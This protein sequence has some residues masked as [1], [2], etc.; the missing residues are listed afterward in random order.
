MKRLKT[1]VLKT[2]VLKTLVGVVL[3][4]GTVAPL[5]AHTFAPSLFEL[6]Q[7]DG[8]VAVR[9]K[10]P[11]VRVVD[12]DLGGPYPSPP[13]GWFAEE[14]FGRGIAGVAGADRGDAGSVRIVAVF[15]D[16]RGWKGRAGLSDDSRSAVRK[17][18]EG[19]GQVVSV[20]FGHPR[21]ATQLPAGVP[22]VC[23]WGGERIMQEAAGR[24]LAR[25]LKGGPAA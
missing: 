2:L 20:L 22:V 7:E 21:M 14:L 1:L 9:F 23:A 24:V 5:A 3:V 4:L 13:R 17:A 6:R 8:G 16:P 19:A 10:Q 18:V 15:A 25:T 11:E 12:D